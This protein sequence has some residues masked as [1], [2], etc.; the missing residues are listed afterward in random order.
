MCYCYRSCQK[1]DMLQHKGKNEAELTDGGHGGRFWLETESTS[2]SKPG[3]ARWRGCGRTW[4]T[5]WW[6]C[7]IQ[8]VAG[9][10]PASSTCDGDDRSTSVEHHR[11]GNGKGRV[12]GH[13]ESHQEGYGGVEEAE[14]WPE[15]LNLSPEDGGQRR[16]STNLAMIESLPGRFLAGGWRGQRGASFGT[17]G[18]AR[19]CPW[20][21]HGRGM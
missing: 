10:P 1:K 6:W 4:G 21:R 3:R 15:W 18:S 19:E 11:T 9:V 13:V 12:S 5:G 16:E 20:R 2:G 8:G 14:G 17:F 7:S